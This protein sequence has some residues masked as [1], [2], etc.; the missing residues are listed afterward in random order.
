VELQHQTCLRKSLFPDTPAL[1]VLIDR[2]KGNFAAI[3]RAVGVSKQRAHQVIV[4][5]GLAVF[6]AEVRAEAAA[7][8]Q[9]RRDAERRAARTCTCPICARL[10]ERDHRN[11]TTCSE[12]CAREKRLRCLRRCRL[13]R[14]ER[15]GRRVNVK[16]CGVCRVPGH[17]KR[18]CAL[19]VRP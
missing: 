1:R 3:G 10:F 7:T 9:A 6:A 13:V 14:D 15:Q 4:E 17:N 19:A 18:T 2:H 16:P 5:R 11:Q 8:T 12:A